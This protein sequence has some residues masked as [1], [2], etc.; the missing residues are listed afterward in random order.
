MKT[1]AILFLFVLA[2]CLQVYACIPPM[3]IR[4]RYATKLM[5]M[6][7][8]ALWF[9]FSTDPTPRAIYAGLLCGFLGDLLLLGSKKRSFLFVLGSAFFAVGHV[10]YAVYFL[11]NLGGQPGALLIAA[12]AC[13]YFLGIFLL[14]RLFKANISKKLLATNGTPWHYA[15]FFASLL[16]LLSDGCL[17]YDKFYRPFPMRSVVVMTTY[18][19]AQAGITVSLVH[20]LGGF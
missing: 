1:H 19:L 15:V 13:G 6:P 18:I 7:L 20:I 5:L 16:F 10:L 17:S 2:A 12:A 11:S 8:L 14:L 3:R 9:L 4:L